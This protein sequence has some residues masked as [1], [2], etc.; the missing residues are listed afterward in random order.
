MIVIEES[1]YSF[2]IYDAP[3][4]YAVVVRRWRDSCIPAA[5]LINFSLF[6]ILNGIFFSEVS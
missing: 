5:G 6:V 3:W 2:F 1:K 4:L